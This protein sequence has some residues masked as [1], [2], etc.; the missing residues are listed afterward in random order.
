V[1]TIGIFY[2]VIVNLF[3]RQF[4]LGRIYPMLVTTAGLSGA[5]LI[6]GAATGMAWAPTQSGFR[7]RRADPE[8]I[9]GRRA[10]I[11]LSLRSPSSC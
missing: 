4:P 11:S 6:I 7:E 5:I 3:Y 2:A 8:I 1:S 9:A 10:N